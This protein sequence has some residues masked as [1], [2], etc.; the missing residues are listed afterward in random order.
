MIHAEINIYNVKNLF[1]KNQV[2]YFLYQILSSPVFVRNVPFGCS[3]TPNP[4]TL[5][6]QDSPWVDDKFPV[7]A[8]GNRAQLVPE[9]N[10]RRLF[11]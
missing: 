8:L 1:V 10:R 9:Q 6:V 7:V 2:K 3:E 5:H 11:H 4:E